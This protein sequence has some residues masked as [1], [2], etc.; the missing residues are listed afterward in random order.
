[1]KISALLPLVAVQIAVQT[2]VGAPAKRNQIGDAPGINDS[3]FI[4]RIM[5]AHWYWRKIHCAQDLIW[6]AELAKAALDSVSAC[7]DRP[8]HVSTPFS[9]TNSYGV[10]TNSTGPRR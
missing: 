6:D 1:M 3:N 5:D 2:A 7:T 9:H 10:L 4:S 8:Q